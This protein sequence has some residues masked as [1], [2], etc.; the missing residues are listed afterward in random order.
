MWTMYLLVF[1]CLHPLGLCLHE[2]ILV[3]VG[4]SFECEHTSSLQ[5]TQI[6]FVNEKLL[7]SHSSAFH[8]SNRPDFLPK[9]PQYPQDVDFSIHPPSPS[10]HHSLL[11]VNIQELSYAVW[12][13]LPFITVY[14]VCLQQ[15]RRSK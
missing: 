7:F 15:W 2:L 5:Y 10:H 8:H 9:Y 12:F 6:L 3:C 4:G 13:H 1:V 11:S 14:I